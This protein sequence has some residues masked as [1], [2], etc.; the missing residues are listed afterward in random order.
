MIQVFPLIRISS[1][2]VGGVSLRATSFRGSVTQ[3]CPLPEAGH[4][5]GAEGALTSGF[6]DDALWDWWVSSQKGSHPT[7]Q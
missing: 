5:W 1:Y 6:A 2:T 7:V 4:S 3:A